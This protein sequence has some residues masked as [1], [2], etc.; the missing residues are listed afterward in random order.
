MPTVPLPA[1]TEETNAAASNDP[2]AT[3]AEAVQAAGA[4]AGEEHMNDC[5]SESILYAMDAATI[6]DSPSE[7]DEPA[8]YGSQQ[9]SS[10]YGI[11]GQVNSLFDSVGD[12]GG[13]QLST[14]PQS[15]EVS[16]QVESMD[17]EDESSMPS[18]VYSMGLS[19]LPP[20]VPSRPADAQPPSSHPEPLPATDAE[21]SDEK[22][23]RLMQFLVNPIM[24]LPTSP[25]AQDAGIDYG[26]SAADIAADSMA[27]HIA[28]EADQE[29]APAP[30]TSKAARVADLQAQLAAALAELAAEQAAT[31]GGIWRP[32][33]ACQSFMPPPTAPGE[34]DAGIDYGE[35]AA[36]IAADNSGRRIDA[37][38]ARELLR[39]AHGD[40]VDAVCLFK[41]HA[42]RQGQP[43]SSAAA[44]GAPA[45][46]Q[47]EAPAISIGA[48]CLVQPP[49]PPHPSGACPSGA[50]VGGPGLI[51]ASPSGAGVGGT[52]LSEAS[53]SGATK[54]TEPAAADMAVR[55]KPPPGWT[56]VM[57]FGKP[58]GYRSPDGRKAISLP[59]A[60]RLY[61]E[62]QHAGPSGA[63]VGGAGLSE[64][65]PSGAGTL[66]HTGSSR[67]PGP[68]TGCDTG[69][70]STHA[71]PQR[72]PMP[73][74]AVLT[75]G[76][77]QPRALFLPSKRKK[78]YSCSRCGQLNSH[79]A[80]RCPFPDEF[81][82]SP[83]APP[84]LQPAAAPPHQHPTVPP[85]A[86]ATA[87]AALS[88]SAQPQ[89]GSAVDPIVIDAALSAQLAHM[90][91]MGFSH[92]ES[93]WA[94]ENAR[95]DIYE[96]IDLLFKL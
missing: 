33:R 17:E 95:G 5:H 86:A 85:A 75:H 19:L 34:H 11:G 4:A 41:E 26:E 81:R 24:P 67:S 15:A 45:I 27:V 32:T 37:A 94:L 23:A 88:A 30:S 29:M 16:G 55:T 25:G 7:K 80:P 92:A 74:G 21:P 91:A 2:A 71:G 10:S 69:S 78:E 57:D 28:A 9:E 64:A 72:M 66:P 87:A 46:Q 20:L 63:G 6:D 79:Y 42:T 49:S 50:G 13:L 84:S 31:S 53:P 90:R 38:S 1:G 83:P 93:R 36:D 14:E 3:A 89:A 61:D 73:Q 62:Q 68:S 52:G 35:I 60:W 58:K 18:Q 22:I 82:S 54:S 70:S 48:L 65:S 47:G 43:S 56:K 77:F 44:A 59:A 12:Y 96:A 40:T 39:Q 8:R 76:T 51:G